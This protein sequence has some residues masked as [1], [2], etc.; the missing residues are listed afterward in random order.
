MEIYSDGHGR[1]FEEQEISKQSF[2][3]TYFL[4]K[5]LKED[6]RFIYVNKLT[7]EDVKKNSAS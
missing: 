6:G 7:I 2:I 1:V 4:V 5:A 3:G